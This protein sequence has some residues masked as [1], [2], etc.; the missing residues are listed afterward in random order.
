MQIIK[1]ELWLAVFE[2]RWDCQL[3]GRKLKTVQHE[4]TITVRLYLAGLKIGVMG[5]AY[6]RNMSSRAQMNVRL[7]LACER[8]I[9]SSRLIPARVRSLRSS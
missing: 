6:L 1:P 2:Q 8:S 9:N 7:S 5:N 4:S 3:D